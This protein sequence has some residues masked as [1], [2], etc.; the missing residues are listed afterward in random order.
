MPWLNEDEET[1]QETPVEG[2]NSP[3][4]QRSTSADTKAFGWLDEG[5][6]AKLGWQDEGVSKTTQPPRSAFR[7]GSPRDTQVLVPA[8]TPEELIQ[9]L[10]FG[11]TLLQAGK[12]VGDVIRPIA[13]PYEKYVAKP[14][15]E[16]LGYMATGG[17][18]SR[19]PLEVV[20][21]EAPAFNAPLSEQ[22]LHL[23]KM[24]VIG[25]GMDPLT[26]VSPLGMVSKVGKLASPDSPRVPLQPEPLAH[27]EWHGPPEPRREWQGPPAPSIQDLAKGA[28][29]M[30]TEKFVPPAPTSPPPPTQAPSSTKLVRPRGKKGAAKGSVPPAEPATPAGSSPAAPSGS[31][32]GG[33]TGPL[34]QPPGFLSSRFLH[35]QPPEPPP[36]LKSQFELAEDRLLAKQV[37]QMMRYQKLQ[38][39]RKMA[40][41][42]ETAPP[43]SPPPPVD[44]LP[45]HPVDPVA[46]V[47]DSAAQMGP[48]EPVAGAAPRD[49]PR[50]RLLQAGIDVLRDLHPSAAKFAN[51]LEYVRDGSEQL[52]MTNTKDFFQILS[53]HMGK[54]TRFLGTLRGILN[55]NMQ[56]FG[57]DP[58][59][60]R[61]FNEILA[62]GE[63]LQKKNF[64]KVDPSQRRDI[65]QSVLPSHSWDQLRNQLIDPRIHAAVEEG[66]QAMTGRASA[67]PTIQ[68]HGTIRDAVTGDTYPMGK[69]TPYLPQVPISPKL[70]EKLSE[71]AMKKM[72]QD[73]QLKGKMSYE[74]FKR[75]IKEI[76]DNNDP[77]VK[78]ML[79]KGVTSARLLDVKAYARAEGLTITD[80]LKR[81]GYEYDPTRMVLKHNLY[82]YRTALNLE[83]DTELNAARTEVEAHYGP[84]SPE[85]EYLDQVNHLSQGL[86]HREDILDKRTDLWS[87]SQAILYPIFLKAAWSQNMTLQQ[88]HLLMRTGL[89]PFAVAIWR[90]LGRRV[91]MSKPEIE[92]AMDRSAGIFPAYVARY[93]S[94]KGLA[95]Q[96]SKTANTLNFFSPADSL[97]RTWAN[98]VGW[99]HGEM[100][101]R[102]WWRDREN[103]IYKQI[104]RDAHIDPD[105]LR[106][107]MMSRPSS[108]WENDMPPIPTEALQRYAQTL[109]NQSMG[110]TGI[111][112]LPLWAS[113]PKESTRI[114]LMLHRQMLANERHIIQ[115]FKGLKNVPPK[116]RLT[117]GIQR[118]A[119]LIAGAE[120]T[121]SAYQ[122][123]LNG[124]MGRDYLQ[125]D[126]RLGIDDEFTAFFAKSLALGLG[127]VTAGL[128]LSGLHVAQGNYGGAAYGFLTPPVASLVD[129]VANKIF[130]G[131]FGEAAMKLQPSETVKILHERMTREEKELKKLHGLSRSSTRMTP[132][133]E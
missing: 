127:T 48:V 112:N 46:G 85:L 42:L 55:P 130:Q 26:I 90:D 49:L 106:R 9:Q 56:R 129:E 108:E 123:L 118:A 44:A 89:K 52:A 72:Y 6:G 50:F 12:R 23:G 109:A 1:A 119:R 47:L 8:Y 105:E 83:R 111:H 67:H 93:H 5:S 33:P 94:P 62:Y 57:F 51:I 121:G 36:P 28:P 86:S 2:S 43:P 75:R 17:E 73:R 16:A 131:K 110:R 96:F 104:L 74:E 20:G 91:G 58:K 125:A 120:A 37:E 100:I 10:P 34:D 54:D 38:E 98:Q 88:T 53:K 18:E 81:L 59:Q 103:P 31:P 128:A 114:F 24:A 21:A 115:A 117:V 80:A 25:A 13:E 40:A 102:K 71:R 35:G 39:E 82:S 122:I 7:Q 133:K 70:K 78:Y 30:Q 4:D 79:Y 124:L 14:V 99:V 92:A 68:A 45:L 69:P 32:T 84:H 61:A 116:Q 11:E 41:S 77:D 76:L 97:T 113:L 22:A 29:G 126:Q 95:D 19:D 87:L 15:R 66:W 65:L 64:W 63:E 3:Q 132:P 60:M 27:N 101:I 107:R